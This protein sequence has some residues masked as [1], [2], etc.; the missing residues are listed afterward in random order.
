[1]T[2][3]PPP[4][5][6]EGAH[7]RASTRTSAGATSAASRSTR[8]SGSRAKPIATMDKPLC[9][10]IPARVY[11]ASRTPPSLVVGTIGQFNGRRL[12]RSGRV[13]RHGQHPAAA[14]PSKV[15]PRARRR[16]TTAASPTA[17]ARLRRSLRL[18]RRG[19]H[20]PEPYPEPVVREDRVRPGRA[21]TRWPSIRS[22]S[23]RAARRRSRST[24]WR[25]TRPTRPTRASPRVWAFA[26]TAS[27]TSPASR[28]SYVQVDRPRSD[29]VGQADL[30]DRRLH[31]GHRSPRDNRNEA[32]QSAV[33]DRRSRPAWPL[34]SPAWCASARAAPRRPRTS[35]CARSS[36]RSRWTSSASR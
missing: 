11:I 21:R 23:A 20:R 34:S 8:R 26:A 31:L 13:H 18:E 24:T 15:V 3:Q 14:G 12:V 6:G 30:R 9:G 29:G 19:H 5:P 4:V 17:A 2:V 32:R 35:R 36:R 33:A 7:Y 28:H 16:S 27:P 10:T 1:M 22:A 25:P